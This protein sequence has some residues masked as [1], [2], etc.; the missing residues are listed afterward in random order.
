MFI[1][2]Q[3]TKSFYNSFRAYNTKLN[4]HI[5]LIFF[6]TLSKPQNFSRSV[7]NSQK[8]FSKSLF[9]IKSKWKFMS[10]CL[11]LFSRLEHFCFFCCLLEITFLSFL[12]NLAT[13]KKEE[14]NNNTCSKCIIMFSPY[15]I[16]KCSLAQ[17]IFYIFLIVAN[18]LFN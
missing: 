10:R 9:G 1:L 4:H 2:V 12:T 5:L 16:I 13:S 15:F 6:R 17:S 8:V 14:T 3:T 7:S 11:F 18:I